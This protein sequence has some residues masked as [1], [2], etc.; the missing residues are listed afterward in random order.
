MA[1]DGDDKNTQRRRDA[2]KLSLGS[3]QMKC[4]QHTHNR[5]TDRET[6]VSANV[7]AE[8]ETDSVTDTDTVTDTPLA[9]HRY[10]CINNII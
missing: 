10:I 8:T 2:S 1:I 7:Y 3:T 9:R 5:Q 4:T 6:V